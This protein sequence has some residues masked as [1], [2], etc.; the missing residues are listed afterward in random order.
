MS[1]V[2]SREQLLAADL[3]VAI[4]F[5]GPNVYK[6][7]RG[8]VV[9]RYETATAAQNHLKAEREVLRIRRPNHKEHDVSEIE[10]SRVITKGMVAMSTSHPKGPT[11]AVM[12]GA[13]EIS[14]KQRAGANAMLKMADSV[15]RM[16]PRGEG[17]V[18]ASLTEHEFW[19]CN[20]GDALRV[21]R[22]LECGVELD[23]PV[24]DVSAH[25]TMTPDTPV[26]CLRFCSRH[27]S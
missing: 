26:V 2:P 23:G 10:L 25:G 21:K 18:V 8:A 6:R 19:R 3:P 16:V 11:V 5:D 13:T 9:F 1:T 24:T 22:C 4:V 12:I 20:Y 27:P 14:L 17:V 7:Q 15:V